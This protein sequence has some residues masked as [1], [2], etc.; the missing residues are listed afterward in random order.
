MDK[1]HIE[2]LAKDPRFIP[3]IYNYCDR[4]CE[5]CAFTSRCLN[6]ELSEEE[7]SDPEARDINNKVFW[8]KLNETLSVAMEMMREKAK[9]LGVDLDAMD[10]E[11]TTKENERIREKAKEQP[12][13]FA[14]KEYIGM[15]DDW[16]KAN[17]ERLE[18]K[19]D[20]L[21]SQ[22]QAGIPGIRPD[23]D[24]VRINDC[25]EVISWYKHQIYVKLCRAATGILQTD[26]Y[27]REFSMHDANGSAKVALIGIER[28]MAAWAGLLMHFPD[29]EDDILDLLVILK[30]L[31]PQVESTFPGA[32]S[33]QRPGLDTLH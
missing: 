32:R 23:V 10:S 22:A 25:L 11:E 12:Y 3:G 26:P 33:F 2:E 4:W 29:Q 5:R 18:E 17:A 24:A 30:R 1:E 20:E 19:G 13:C 21:V 6:F 7:T 28:S 8:N 15:V 14:A 27:E 9:E 31:L 16:F